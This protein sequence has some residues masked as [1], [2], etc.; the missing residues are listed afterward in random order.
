MILIGQYD[1]PFVRRVAIALWL[2]GLAY[3]HR[4]WSTFSD[5]EQI[6]RFNPLRRVP[7]LVLDNGETL[8]E[9]T[10]ILDYVD[11]LV[12]PAK[13]L[14]PASG[15]PRRMGLKVC[16][17]ATGLSD[18]A[19]S[20]LYERLMH[21]DVS[22][23]WV[24]RCEQQIADALDVLEADHAGLTTPFWFGDSAGHPDIAVACA[25]RFTREAHPA[26]FDEQRWPSLAA[27]ARRCEALEPFQVIQ[28]PFTLPV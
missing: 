13:A 10:V 18:K 5:A 22:Q 15:P 19:F 26:L 21:R 24:Q 28:Q 14:I 12:G 1:S 17:L 20:L 3:E 11:A 23:T 8:I 25:L 16:A 27:H 6:A 4:P 7:T 9:S 2:Y